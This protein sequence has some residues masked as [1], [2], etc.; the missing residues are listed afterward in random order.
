MIEA[1]GRLWKYLV[2]ETSLHNTL[3]AISV[4]IVEFKSYRFNLPNLSQ[5]KLFENHDLSK[6]V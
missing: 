5:S 2:K 6:S 4:V 1:L 3:Q